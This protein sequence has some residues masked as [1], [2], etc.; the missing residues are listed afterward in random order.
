MPT[1]SLRYRYFVLIHYKHSF[2]SALLIRKFWKWGIPWRKQSEQDARAVCRRDPATDS[3]LEVVLFSK[4]YAALVCHRV[5]YR[6]W[7]SKKRRK[8]TALF[9]QSQA[10]ATFGLDVHPAA[11]MGSGIMLD[12]GTGIVIGETATVGDGCT[13]LHGVT[14]G[15]TGKDHGDRHPK[16]AEN[17]LIGAGSS[18]LGN[19]HVGPGAKIGAGSVV[20]RDIPAGRDCCRCSRQDYWQGTRASTRK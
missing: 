16:I 18:I 2:E 7:H 12:H 13:L 11:Q 8:Y 19:I 10:S 17:V 3:V 20:L 5:A 14:L 1:H 6:L 4:G 9:L 15:G